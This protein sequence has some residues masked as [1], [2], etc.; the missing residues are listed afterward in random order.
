[1][2]VQTMYTVDWLKGI[3][4]TFAPK[5]PIAERG[6]AMLQ[7]DVPEMSAS[8]PAGRLLE[9]LR[10]TALEMGGTI[11][12]ETPATE[13]IVENGK[14]CGIRAASPDG[15]VEI[16]AQSVILACGSYPC[17]YE[18]VAEMIPELYDCY[19]SGSVSDT[20]DGIRM[21]L[22]AGAALWEDQWVHPAWPSPTRTFIEKNPLA[23][24]FMDS[25]SPLDVA[26][27]SYYR[28]MVDKNG[29]RF[30]NEAAHYSNQV[31]TMAYN[32]VQP[33]WSLYDNLDEQVTAIAESGLE[34]G[35]VVKGNTIAEVAAA[36]GMDPA[37][38]EA[39]VKRYNELAEAGEDADFGKDADHLKPYGDGPFYLVQM[40]PA[41]TDILGGVQTNYDQQV[42]DESGAVI[43]GLYAVGSMSN[44]QYYNQWYFSG[45][46]LTF[47][48][49]AGKIAGAHAA[50]TL[51]K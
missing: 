51:N 16:R 7:V 28:L 20:G 6:M 46:S 42:L 4:A 2:L 22:D 19:S 34:T 44:K 35:T 15:D 8:T 30:M 43:D 23:T 50:A 33:Y 24:V 39:T 47:A 11:L 38:L 13:L 25:S 17:N 27:S 31:L 26:E 18:M 9:K 21:A 45:S 40:I 29:E 37:V 41:S 3:G 48:S 1:M 12:L 32:G 49:T 14:V 36:A 5:T 10:D